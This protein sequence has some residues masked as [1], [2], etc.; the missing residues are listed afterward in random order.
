MGPGPV[1]RCHLAAEISIRRL[2]DVAVMPLS[3]LRQ[4]PDPSFGLHWCAN[5][6]GNASTAGPRL[7]TVELLPAMVVF[8][9]LPPLAGRFYERLGPRALITVGQGGMTL[10]ALNLAIVRMCG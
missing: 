3:R 10:A 5:L 7:A 6:E 2:A 1:Q 9:I 8:A 4:Y